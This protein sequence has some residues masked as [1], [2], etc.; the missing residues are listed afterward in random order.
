MA[1]REECSTY[2]S[3]FTQGDWFR[4]S[5]LR[6]HETAIGPVHVAA[7]DGDEPACYSR[8]TGHG[9]SRIVFPDRKHVKHHLGRGLAQTGWKMQDGNSGARTV[10]MTHCRREIWLVLSAMI[11]GNLVTQP[12]E[13]GH[14]I[15]PDEVGAT[16]DEHPH[17]SLATT[18]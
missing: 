10:D 16:Y 6:P 12:M 5:R 7:T 3:I 8:E 13:Q 9:R 14:H 15:W 2:W 18:S 1:V 17:N 4:R 11:Q